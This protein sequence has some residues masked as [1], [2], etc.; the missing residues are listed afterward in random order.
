MGNKGF[1]AGRQH[2]AGI[3][4]APHAPMVTVARPVVGGG[5][6]CVFQVSV[7]ASHAGVG[8]ERFYKKQ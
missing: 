2:S 6:V 8:D 7:A 3:D 4:P 5:V 1:F